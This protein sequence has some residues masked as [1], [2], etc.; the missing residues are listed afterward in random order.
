VKRRTCWPADSSTACELETELKTV[1]KYAKKGRYDD[2]INSELAWVEK[3]PDGYINGWFYE[4]ISELYLRKAKIDG[5]RAEEYLRQAVYYRDRAVPSASDDSYL[6]QQLAIVSES[7]GDLS[8]AQRCVQYRNS[9]KLLDRMKLLANENKDH[10]ERQ[11][12]P[13]IDERQKAERP[14]ESIDK[15][16]KRVDGKLSAPGCQEQTS[17]PG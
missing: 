15:I 8:I 4:E 1:E 11:F 17:S 14:P 2:A 12:K 3:H 13:D 16:I 9:I 5:G 6:L 10:L 7:I